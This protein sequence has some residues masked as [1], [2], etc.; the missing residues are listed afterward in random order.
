MTRAGVR[1]ARALGALVVLLVVTATPALAHSNV[2]RS[3]PPNGGM[4]APGRTELTLWFDAPVVA[5]GS[6]FT[7]ERRDRDPGPVRVAAS[8]DAGGSV[9]RLGVPGLPTG[10]YTLTWAVTGA[11]GHPTHGTV[12][13]G[14]GFR[15][16]GIATGGATGP[17]PAAVAVRLLD[18]GGVLVALGSLVVSGRVLRAL[19]RTGE[20]L[21]P[22]VLAVGFTGALFA[23]VGVLLT[24]L[25]SAA[26]QV[27]DAAGLDPWVRAVRD[28]VL[29]SDW[30]VL[31]CVRL[32][33]LAVAAAGLATVL[34]RPRPAVLRVVA[35]AL[36][37][38][39]VVDGWA[40][41]AASLPARTAV[42]ALVAALH[43]LA[44]SVWAGGLLVLVVAVVP[45]MRL[46]SPTRRAL[47][48]ATWRAF[49]PLAVTS[50]AVL[51]ATGVYEA[52]RHV[53][54]VGTALESR[55]GL[56]L[57]GKLLLVGVVLALAGYNAL[58][59]EAPV[60]ERVGRL[61]GRGPGWRPRDHR[62]V[63]TV[64]AEAL[65]LLAVV[66]VTAAMTNVPTAREADLARAVAAPHTET[67]DG[68][69]VSA[70][71]VPTG[72]SLH[73]VVRTEPVVRPVTAPVTG[74]EVVAV[75]GDGSVSVPASERVAL[76]GAE[77]ART[78]GRRFEGTVASPGEG[79]WTAIVAVRRAGRP[80]A[81]VRVAGETPSPSAL[82]GL[83]A[84]G[85]AGC[86]TLLALTAGALV[87]A[88][89]RRRDPAVV[90]VRA[91]P[92]YPHVAL[93]EASR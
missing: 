59:V 1:L 63:T 31:W 74:V 58:L 77:E 28:L 75:R 80:D 34:R 27:G 35:V 3:D 65:A 64:T 60:A 20:R 69:F 22:R 49:G 42:A 85:T 12:V 2:Q 46:D 68:W 87:L 15:P 81:V 52:G 72:S 14:A 67:V 44:A 89:R 78:G 43:V 91:E 25:L 24:P 5:S 76:R 93:E 40:G 92:E 21:R 16:D 39:V 10:T 61:L 51:V 26:N 54:S 45:L 41:H 17:A 71:L 33:G 88:R 50:S 9:V 79:A 8:V 19:G 84:A 66:A 11:D 73:V 4:V 7:L 47:T 30:G 86:L 62:L 32:L 83:E 56:A 53:T 57:A 70:E 29:A 90:E 48:P 36:V 6:T 38:G 37:V 23:F 82:T 13:F 18:L 55:Y